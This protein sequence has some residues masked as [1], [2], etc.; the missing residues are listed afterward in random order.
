MEVTSDASEHSMQ[1]VLEGL[2]D[3]ELLASIL[4]FVVDCY[5]EPSF[6]WVEDPCNWQSPQYGHFH[7]WCGVCAL[8]VENE[9]REGLEEELFSAGCEDCDAVRTLRTVSK[10]FQSMAELQE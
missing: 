8:K 6:C 5:A 4:S 9:R 1:N 2:P 3:D 7:F 10:K